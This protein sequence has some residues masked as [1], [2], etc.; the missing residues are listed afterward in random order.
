MNAQPTNAELLALI[1]KLQADNAKLKASAPTQRLSFKVTAKKPDG[2]GSDG[3]VSVYGLGRF[4]VGAP[5]GLGRRADRVHL[6]QR[7][8][9]LPQVT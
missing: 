8:D 9:H 1:A 5:L 2:T 3:A 4:P 6:G 7:R